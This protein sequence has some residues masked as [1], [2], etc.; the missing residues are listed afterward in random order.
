MEMME[1]DF[2]KKSV[3]LRYVSEWDPRSSGKTKGGY[4]EGVIRG[5]PREARKMVLQTI[6]DEEFARKMERELAHLGY[7]LIGSVH[8]LLLHVV[9]MGKGKRD[10]ELEPVPTFYHWR[11]DF[12]LDQQNNVRI[13]NRAS[14][15]DVG[16]NIPVSVTDRRSIVTTVN[17][18][19]AIVLGGK[20]GELN[21]IALQPKQDGRAKADEATVTKVLGDR[22]GTDDKGLIQSVEQLFKK[23]HSSNL[24][25][26][27]IRADFYDEAG[28]NI[29]FTMS[30]TIKDTGNKKSGAMDLH[31]VSAQKSC[32]KGGRKIFMESEYSL[33]KDVRPVFQVYDEADNHWPE[34]DE[35]LNQP[36]GKAV[37]VRNNAIH[38]ITPEQQESVIDQLAL[39]NK[40]IFLL[41][42]RDSDG[43]CSPRKFPFQYDPHH[44]THCIFCHF[45]PDTTCEGEK[46]DLASGLQPPKPGKGKRE[47]KRIIKVED[48]KYRAK[49][50]KVQIDMC[51]SP[52][53][54]S[55]V[56]SSPQSS[57]QH[58]SPLTPDSGCGLSDSEMYSDSERDWTDLKGTQEIIEAPPGMNHIV[59]GF[60]AQNFDA[61]NFESTEIPATIVGTSSS[62]MSREE[63]LHTPQPVL[64]SF[65]SFFSV[66]P[67]VS[68]ISTPFIFTRREDVVADCAVRKDRPRPR[69]Q[70]IQPGHHQ[71]PQERRPTMRVEPLK[72][73][74]ETKT[75][76]EKEEDEEKKEN[77][78]LSYFPRLVITLILVGIVAS[79]FGLSS[80]QVIWAGLVTLLCVGA[81]ALY[82]TG[83]V[84]RLST[85]SG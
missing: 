69:V 84:S 71:E 5:V 38:I 34:D 29:G 15:L 1:I 76:D 43:Y 13:F 72:T 36:G 62:E 66:K 33:A 50:P 75:E 24:K 67:S 45:Y 41:F 77:P 80:Q 56:C 11:Q 42:K 47:L 70:T 59:D 58:L 28:Y 14:D 39:E 30:E 22:L 61:F 17:S 8:P 52:S 16:R 2:E 53:P 68:E 78:L 20:R 82:Q 9:R 18:Q 55:S 65:S 25:M 79:T 19:G 12:L 3:L 40:T 4:M 63:T 54:S 57:P 21:L 7:H 60:F 10:N 73:E 44:R 81:A 27:R 31:D 49:V 74:T 48:R 35:K 51:P 26:F 37:K 23:V 64:E 6:P 32:T 85:S 46:P 83:L